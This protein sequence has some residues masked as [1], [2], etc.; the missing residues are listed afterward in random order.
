MNRLSSDQ[1]DQ[2]L[3]PLREDLQ[4]MPGS[5]T[6]D[7]QP[8]WTLFDP[9]RDRYF[10]ISWP[11]FQLLSRWNG[12]T[13]NQ[14][15][16]D[17]AATTTCRA[18]EA[19]IPGLL[20][21]L[22]INQLLQSLPSGSYRS[23]AEQS[24]A[25]PGGWFRWLVH[26]YLFVRIP[27]CR[28]DR[29]LRATLPW[30]MRLWSPTARWLWGGLG[31][32]GIY[33]AARQWDQ[34]AHAVRDQFS[35]EQAGM[36]V[37][38]LFA[39][40]VL[41]E[42]GHAYTATR[43]GCRVTSMGVALL[44]MVPV[45]YTDTTDSWKLSSRR[46]RM[47]IAAA[48]M[49]VELVVA[50][51]ATFAWNF[52]PNGLVRNAACLLATI[53]WTM[54]LAVNINPLFRF[55]GYFVL[56]DGLGIPNLQDRAFALGRWQLRRLL[57]GWADA[58]PEDLSPQMR[59]LL[60]VYAWTVWGFRAVVFTGIALLVYH[61]FFK[62]LGLLLFAV[63]IGW[64]ILQPVA[65]ELRVWWRLTREQKWNRRMWISATALAALTVLCFLPWS[66]RVSLPAVLQSAEYATLFA[67]EPARITRLS[68]TPGQR[69]QPGDELLALEAPRMKK[70]LAVTQAHVRT[71]E[72]RANRVAAAPDD[73]A[74][75]QIIVRSLRSRLAELEGLKEKVQRLRL[76]APIA[77]VVTDVTDSLHPGRWV[78][79][80]LPLVHIAQPDRPEC[81]AFAS[82]EDLPRLAV[83]QRAWFLPEHP[84]RASV[85][86][87]VAEIRPVDDEPADVPYLATLYGG[88]IP[89]S[90]DPRD[91]TLRP[92]RSTYRIRLTPAGPVQDV[93]QIVRG[94][95]W[96]EAASKS[97]ARRAWESA[98]GVVI[99]ESGF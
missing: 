62:L 28:P 11:T 32:A 50:A 13:A 92:E 65:S 15:I 48:G 80:Q 58:P 6:P 2:P 27:L 29:F 37:L 93:T 19:D 31:A 95:V 84:A 39:V 56:S 87:R 17:L 75:V 57:F 99:R 54:S 96:I 45:L 38:A 82:E 7:G 77:G 23:L 74:D 72:L 71:L 44:V 81:L 55:D 66:T 3:P 88:T 91:Q 69:V 78:N 86:A 10:Q 34:F 24:D 49:G 98:M 33:L 59:R 68:A 70:D 47:A 22:Q 79:E 61:L 89:M 60:I 8:T 73:L 42:L 4:L 36:I 97:V 94:T 26:H 18:T 83:G 63:E 1:P 46:R 40:K 53:S 25:R 90:K 64:F 35:W 67:P 20:R 51:V 41:H 9:I 16:E 12:R 85:A 52:L 43:Y 76:R 21:F 14:V 5:P 30:A